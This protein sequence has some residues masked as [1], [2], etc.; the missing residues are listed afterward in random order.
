V[1]QRG[2]L[3]GGDPH[4]GSFLLLACERERK[5]PCRRK[6]QSSRLPEV[7]KGLNRAWRVKE[8]SGV[9]RCA[10]ERTSRLIFTEVP[11]PVYTLLGLVFG[12]SGCKPPQ[13]TYIYDPG[14]STARV[15]E[16]EKG[17]VLFFLK[18]M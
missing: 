11:H 4:R 14:T 1:T 16:V 6:E 13:S 17:R 3:P 12:V 10:C 2:A 15:V 9:Q 5:P 7:R 8:H 18:R